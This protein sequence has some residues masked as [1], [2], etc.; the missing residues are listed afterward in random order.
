[1]CTYNELSKSILS[2]CK[3]TWEI[4]L[5]SGYLRVLSQT[6]TST[7]MN[8][9]LKVRKTYTTVYNNCRLKDKL[10]RCILICIAKLMI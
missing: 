5:T 10:F 9:E 1:M 3:V 8:N 6:F 7:K 2:E 4:N